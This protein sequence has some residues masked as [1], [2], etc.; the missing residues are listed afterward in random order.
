MLPDLLILHE[1]KSLHWIPLQ[2]LLFRGEQY[3]HLQ[4]IHI[5]KVHHLFNYLGRSLMDHVQGRVVLELAKLVIILVLTDFLV[6]CTIHR[7]TKPRILWAFSTS[8]F[9]CSTTFNEPCTYISKL[10]AFKSFLKSALF[11]LYF[12][13]I[14]LPKI[15]TIN[16]SL[17]K[18]I[19]N[20]T[21]NI[22]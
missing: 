6:F 21:P 22:L 15:Y 3:Q 10:S 11:S 7:M 4:S 17:L 2:L 14:F 1:F 13:P 8:S 16:M 20:L 12:F 5:I 18:L 9:T 19:C